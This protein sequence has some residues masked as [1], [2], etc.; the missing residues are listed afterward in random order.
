MDRFIASVRRAAY[1]TVNGRAYGAAKRRTS[2]VPSRAV[3]CA[4][5]TA[6]ASSR[7]VQSI[8]S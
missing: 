6:I 8:T 3:G 2:I 7:P 4:A 5:A 1:G